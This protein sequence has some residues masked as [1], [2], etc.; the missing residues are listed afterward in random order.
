M[1][2]RREHRDFTSL[3][4]SLLLSHRLVVSRSL[5]LALSLSCSLA[6]NGVRRSCNSGECT[7]APVRTHS[8]RRDLLREFRARRIE[9]SIRE[10][11]ARRSAPVEGEP[12]IRNEIKRRAR[13]YELARVTVKTGFRLTLMK[14]LIESR[15]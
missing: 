14:Y 15:L 13:C 6:V 3:S 5:S 12:L 2:I 10:D 11:R 8:E 1:G 9:S 7:D 4:L